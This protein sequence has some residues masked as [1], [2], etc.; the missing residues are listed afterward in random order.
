[1]VVAVI[2]ENLIKV[3]FRLVTCPVDLDG[4]YVVVFGEAAGPPC[5]VLENSWSTESPVSDEKGAFGFDLVSF[6]LSL[7]NGNSLEVVQA[8]VVNFEGEK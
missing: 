5:G 7:G 3:V 4:E 1:M 8:W 6:D 2:R